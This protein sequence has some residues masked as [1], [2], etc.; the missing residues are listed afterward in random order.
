V[1]RLTTDGVGF[2]WRR[3]IRQS[4]ATKNAPTGPPPSVSIDIWS[5]KGFANLE[6]SHDGARYLLCFVDPGNVRMGLESSDPDTVNCFA[7]PG[8][9]VLQKIT[10]SHIRSAIDQLVKKGFFDKLASVGIS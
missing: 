4:E 10:E 9:V 8:M 3:A 2:S 1:K 7:E 6:V 5:S